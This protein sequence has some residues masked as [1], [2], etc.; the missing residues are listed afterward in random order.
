MSANAAQLTTTKP[1]ALTL[2]VSRPVK[3]VLTLGGI[4][5]VHLLPKEVL[6]GQ[7]TRALRRRLLMLL[8]LIVV[9]AIVGVGAATLALMSANAQLANEQSRSSLLSVEQGKYGK[10]TAIQNQV[11]DIT[12]AQPVAAGGEILWAPYLQTV[13][14]T[15]P[16]GTTITAFTAQLVDP[17]AAPVADSLLGAHAAIL[18]LTADSPQASISDWLD[19]LRTLK[20]FVQATPGTV[21]L[22]PE[23][24]RYTVGVDLLISNAALANQ[25]VTEKKK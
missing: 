19:N 13:Q 2:T 1:K 6:A 22:V 11:N 20:G 17:A 14:A 18:S 9:V 15:L 5:R 3:E 23:T 10:V 4:P 8:V 12:T 21:T 16:V 25:F 7:K 24:G